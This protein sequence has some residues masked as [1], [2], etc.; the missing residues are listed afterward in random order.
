MTELFQKD[1][2]LSDAGLRAL[3]AGEPDELGRLEAAEH[4]SFCDGCLVRYTALLEGDALEEPPADQTLPVM[5]RLRRRLTQAL[6]SRYAAAAAALIVTGGLWYTG[7]FAD[8][9]RLLVAGGAETDRPAA[10]SV[11]REPTMS[12]TILQ[13]MG[14]WSASVQ[15]ALR[16]AWQAP[17]PETRQTPD[18]PTADAGASD[19]A[20][21]QT[22]GAE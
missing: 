9:A 5:R 18:A 20:T 8:M 16:P 11:Q 17:L 1:G 13:R 4:L 22:K 14:D 21:Q 6:A 15:S 19:A 2:H 12:E 7:V 3:V 10:S